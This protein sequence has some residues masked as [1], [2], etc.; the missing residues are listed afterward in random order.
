[1]VVVL[2]VCAKTGAALVA[3]EAATR[4][5]GAGLLNM[6]VIVARLGFEGLAAESRPA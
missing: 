6:V 1:M 4:R 3:R 5:R 2:V